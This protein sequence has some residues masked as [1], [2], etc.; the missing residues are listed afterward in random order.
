MMEYPKFIPDGKFNRFGFFRVGDE[1]FYSKLDAVH[2]SMAT[3]H[4]VE[5]D[6]NNELFESLDWTTEPTQSIEELYKQRAQQIRDKYDY[7]VVM[8]SGGCDSTAVLDSFVDNKI[9]LDEVMIWHWLDGNNG[10]LHAFMTDEIFHLAIPHALK[11]LQGFDTRVTLHDNSNWERERMQDPETRNQCWR[12]INNI[13]NLALQGRY[14]SP[15][16]GIHQRFQ[17][18]KKLVDQGKSVCFIWAEAKPKISFDQELN[19]HY[20]WIEDH[21]ACLPQP[22][23]QWKNDPTENHEHF[24]TQEELPKLMIKQAHILLNC[25]KE[26]NQDNFVEY[27]HEKRAIMGPH[28]FMVGNPKS[29]WGRTVRDGKD[30]QIEYDV[31]HKL[32]YPGHQPGGYVQ[33]KQV[34]RAVHPAHQWLANE[35]PLEAKHWYRDYINTFSKLPESWTHYRGTLEQNLKRLDKK[36]Y[37]E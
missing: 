15:A 2:H 20:Y 5:W 26:W 31:Y 17:H 6:F 16:Q 3:G 22:M 14:F 36:Y 7:V 12:G 21:Y 33:W 25:V 24:F 23:Q 35:F 1:C 29:S 11:K 28:G 4:E 18:I 10:N 34:G 9:Q 32:I 37:I 8:F 13:H 27:V 19:K 30:W